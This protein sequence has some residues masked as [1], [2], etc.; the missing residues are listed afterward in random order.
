MTPP[1]LPAPQRLPGSL[2]LLRVSLGVTRMALW[3]GPHS[4]IQSQ[5]HFYKESYRQFDFT[6]IEGIVMRRTA[7]GAVYGVIIAGVAGLFG[8][9]AWFVDDPR[10]SILAGAF[11]AIWSLVWAYNVCRGPTCRMQ[12][13]T[14]LGVRDLPTLNRVRPA[15]QAVRL[16]SAAVE[17]AQG[18]LP[19]GEA[20]ERLDQ[21]LAGRK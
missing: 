12:L 17:R 20:A 6:K 2:P 16:I 3:L 14:S 15:R 18:A 8:W 11:A 7:R 5:L 9:A 10:A 13:Q 19:P 21:F 1:P 4:L